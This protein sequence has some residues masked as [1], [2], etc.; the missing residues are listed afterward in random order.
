VLLNALA[1]ANPQFLVDKSV[2]KHLHERALA[3]AWFAGDE[4]DLPSAL[5]GLI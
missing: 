2:L 1:V 4:H 3:N 5:Q